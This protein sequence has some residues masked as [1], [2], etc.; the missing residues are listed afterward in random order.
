MDWSA[1]QLPALSSAGVAVQWLDMDQV[2]T[3]ASRFEA[4]SPDELTRARK[5]AT[6]RLASH[7]RIA[8]AFLRDRLAEKTGINAA[9][10]RYT[11]NH[12][13]K[14][15]LPEAHCQFNL[16]HSDN[17]ALLGIGNTSPIGVDIEK[18]RTF[19][20]K[21]LRSL[22]RTIMT[23]AEQTELDALLNGSAES[24][25]ATAS[26]AFLTAWTRKEACVKALGLGLSFGVENLQVGLT[27]QTRQIAIP[28]DSASGRPLIRMT[29]SSHQ[30]NATAVCSLAVTDPA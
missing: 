2:D 26:Q 4:L 28:A 7:Y 29:L 9:A 14:P 1:R 5:F 15:A 27:G 19:E 13:G 10:I 22:A 24:S 20:T 30:I 8:H 18:F 6:T 3:T 21:E 23:A 12:W 11:T 17:L 16:S 25:A